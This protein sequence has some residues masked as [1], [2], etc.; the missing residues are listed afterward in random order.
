[1]T[2]RTLKTAPPLPNGAEAARLVPT[3]GI[4]IRTWQRM[5]SGELPMPVH[6]LHALA[7]ALDLGPQAMASW[8]VELAYRFSL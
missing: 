1:M 6:R 3:A 8:V 7:W 2:A 5:L 4:T